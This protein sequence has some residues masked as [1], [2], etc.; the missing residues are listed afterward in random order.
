LCCL[1]CEGWIS[2]CARLFRHAMRGLV[3]LHPSVDCVVRQS[4][5]PRCSR[6]ALALLPAGN[7][8]PTLLSWYGLY[9][10]FRHHQLAALL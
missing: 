1:S 6:D 5:N 2:A 3:L 4:Q 8:G 7:Y 9:H 10:Y